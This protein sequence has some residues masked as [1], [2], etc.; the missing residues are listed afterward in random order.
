ME[1]N[2][3]K[4][5]PETNYIILSDGT[6]ARLLK[7]TFI[8]RQTYFNLIINGK[9]KRMNRQDVIKWFNGDSENGNGQDS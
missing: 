2:Q 8:H 6:V 1:N 7:P 4:R 5:Y 9:M 3:Y